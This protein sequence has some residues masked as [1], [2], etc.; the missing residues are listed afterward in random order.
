VGSTV[1]L[2]H[3]MWRLSTTL[4]RRAQI[5][6]I[7]WDKHW[8]G[9]HREF[10]QTRRM[11]G[12]APPESASAEC[13]LCHDCLE[14]QD[15][16]LR[17]CL[18][19][20]I[21]QTR[22]KHIAHIN[23]A[24]EHCRRNQPQLYPA[25]AA[26]HAFAMHHMRGAELWTGLLTSQTQAALTLV[27][28]FHVDCSRRQ[29][30]TFISY[31]RLYAAATLHIY[32]LRTALI[33]TSGQALQSPWTRLGEFRSNI[34][35]VTTAHETVIG[36]DPTMYLDQHGLPFGRRA[37]LKRPKTRRSALTRT[38]SEAIRQGYRLSKPRPA[39]RLP[40]PVP[41]LRATIPNIVIEQSQE[42]EQELREG[43]G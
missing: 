7:V 1:S 27:P 15:H 29:F 4:G 6:R 41:R 13:P 8:T 32:S 36:I 43:I 39:S 16:I 14:D 19:P 33:A 12:G 20:E 35:S 42:Q 38:N 10:T 34:P 18:H 22:R 9:R 30:S 23:A 5:T 28:E 25:L 3:H 37:P 17:C 40:T 26:Y 2:A 24:I 21:T 31:L 11:F